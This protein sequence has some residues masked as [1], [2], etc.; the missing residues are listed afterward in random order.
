MSKHFFCYLHDISCMIFIECKDKCLGQIVHIRF[1]LRVGKHFGIYGITIGLQYQLNLCRVNNTT[2]KFLTS[3][4]FRF[5]VVNSLNLP[6]IACF[7][8]YFITFENSTAILCCLRFDTI[9][10][11]INIYAI[12][13]RLLQRIVYDDIAIEESLRLRNRCCC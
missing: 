12:N 11:T 2:I 8:F 13:D 9:N 4:I 7:S 10:T 1:S 6:R 5:L 3:I